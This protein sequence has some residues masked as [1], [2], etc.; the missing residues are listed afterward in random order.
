VPIA[1]MRNRPVDV[2]FKA[3]GAPND[4]PAPTVLTEPPLLPR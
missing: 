4:L 3:Y 2:N 1:A